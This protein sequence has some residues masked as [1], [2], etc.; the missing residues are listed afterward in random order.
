MN[1][2]ASSRLGDHIAFTRALLH[3]RSAAPSDELLSS[4]RMARACVEASASASAPDVV[5]EVRLGLTPSETAVL[6]LLACGA[7]DPSIREF[8]D[9]NGA[10]TELIRELVYGEREVLAAERALGP[11]G[12][13][14]RL[15]LI[16]RNDGGGGDTHHAKQTWSI[17]RR[18]L[19]WLQGD[20][21]LDEELARLV[22]FGDITG[23]GQLIADEAVV[24][25]ALEAVKTSRSLVVASGAP[26][27]GR[28]S[29]IAAAARE[30]NIDLLEIDAKRLAKNPAELTKQ[31]RL[32]ARECKLLAR[33]PLVRNLD[34]LVDDK[35][36]SKL[37]LVG[38]ELV[39]EL[40]TS[41]FV[42]CGANRPQLRWERPVIVIE[43]KPPS[44]A[45]RAKL[46]MTLLDAAESDG[47]YLATA[48][49]LAPAMMKR[50]LP[51]RR[52]APRGESSRRRMSSSASA[53]RSMTSSGT[54]P[55]AS[56][57]RRAGTT[58]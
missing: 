46:W 44:S 52:R 40:D 20:E 29:L 31:L 1:H 58:W 33:A 6:V 47:E 55:G 9:A 54:S 50:R 49:P 24:A 57:S 25:T 16:E 26:G 30:A 36:S 3:L 53:L 10:T 39:A 2:S 8:L 28:R 7:V 5:L 17:S 12:I 42:T 27:L 32:I 19:M 34:A 38:T 45:Q 15:G 41:V 13:L 51:R 11:R 22:R 56:R 21:E 48:Y 4:V 37:D 43:V 18:V 14:R 23:V 35:D